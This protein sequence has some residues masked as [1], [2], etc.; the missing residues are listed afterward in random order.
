MHHCGKHSWDVARVFL[1][2]TEHSN[3]HAQ[4][5]TDPEIGS[6]ICKIPRRTTSHYR[7]S[8]AYANSVF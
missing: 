4:A 6:G 1:L 5:S 7:K 2:S 3:S 8:A